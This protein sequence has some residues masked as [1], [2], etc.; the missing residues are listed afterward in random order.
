[1]TDLLIKAYDPELFR[2]QGH[3]LID[4]LSSYLIDCR[5]RK[6]IPV[7]SPGQ[8]NDYWKEWKSKDKSCDLLS[9]IEP[10]IAGANHL[11][12]PR[13]AG[14]QVVPPVPVAALGEFVSDLLNNGM[15]IYE[16]GPSGSVIE[17]ETIEWIGKHCGFNEAGG[18]LTSGGT[19]GNLT[20]L[21]AARQQML[22]EN[23]WKNGLRPD[24]RPAVMVSRQSHYSIDRAVRIMGWGD[25]GIIKLD[26]D[27]FYRIDISRL[28]ESLMKAQ[29]EGLQVIAIIGNA[30]T[31]AT[32]TYDDLV[33]LAE[34]AQRYKLWFHID[35]A[36]GGAVVLSEKYKYLAKGLEMA[37]SVVIDFHKLL[38]TPALTTAVLF[39]N[40]K[41]SFQTFAQ[42]ASYL[43]ANEEHPWHDSAMRTIECTKKMMGLK[44][45]IL[46]TLYGDQLFSDYIESRYD[47]TREFA[48]MVIRRPDWEIATEPESNILCFRYAP[49][50]PDITDTNALNEHIRAEFRRIGKYYIVQTRLDGRVY[51]RMTLMNPFTD[52]WEI[53]GILEDAEGFAQTFAAI[54]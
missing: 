38:L 50:Q 43:L 21:L 4:R 7:L 27:E 36:H 24:T 44:I 22:P 52:E 9:V 13:Y 15:A 46:R 1:M 12:H 35:G 3:Q 32:G 29:N 19:L 28:E 26:V 30:G 37:D 31:T 53:N 16:M 42:E 41:H 10:V 45:H 48:K 17:R 20:A 39:K 33:A 2:E 11:H 51:L 23:V 54:K 6:D 40:E 49:V 5:D 18:V 8:P 25:E 47:I 34:F 14:H